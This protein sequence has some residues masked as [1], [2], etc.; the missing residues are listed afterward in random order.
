[1]PENSFSDLFSVGFYNLENFFDTSHDEYTLDK[2]F[3]PEGEMQWDETKYKTKIKNISRAITQIG[4]HK[5]SIPPIFLG[6]AEVENNKVLGDLISSENMKHFD[7]DFVH[8]ESPDERGIDVAFLYQKK[9][10]KLIYS[11]TYTL[12][13]EDKNQDRDYT[14]DILLISG[15]L[16]QEQVYIIV[17]HWPSR[18]NGKRFSESKRIKAARLI[19]KIIEEIREEDQNPNII[20]MGDFNDDP[21]SSSIRKYLVSQ[22]FYN[23]MLEIYRKGKGSLFH[24]GKWH[25]FDQIIL[26]NNFL[27]KK[28]LIFHDAEV[29]S[30]YFLQEKYG[31]SKGAPLRTF[32]GNRYIGGYSDHFPVCI[33]LE[34]EN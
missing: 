20:I 16:F 3:T 4:S 6:V 10:F 22:E 29:M 30:D 33:Y 12:M 32:L 28:G 17:N 34:K 7:Y 15:K 27:S 2:E 24:Q 13:L 31:R 25:I 5:S 9:H 19:H 8:Y 23:P 11:D 14:R 26:T 1:M 21:N 18:N